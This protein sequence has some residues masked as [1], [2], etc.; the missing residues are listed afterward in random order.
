MSAEHVVRSYFDALEAKNLDRVDALVSADLVVVT[1]LRPLGKPDLLGL[2][3]AIFDAFPDWRFDPQE[4]VIA[5]DSVTTKLRM[6][7]THTGTFVPPLRVLKPVKATG[8]KV[9]L[10]EQ[11]FVYADRRDSAT[12]LAD[13]THRQGDWVRS[14]GCSFGVTRAAV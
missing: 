6:A 4:L 11:T 1:P 5:G 9:I 13:A 10:P 2:F 7:G 14:S 3:K 12:A 8:K